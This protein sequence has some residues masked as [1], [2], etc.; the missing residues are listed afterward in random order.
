MFALNIILLLVE[1]NKTKAMDIKTLRTKYPLLLRYLQDQGVSKSTLYNYQREIKVMLSPDSDISDMDQYCHRL[2]KTCKDKGQTLYRRLACIKRIWR[3]VT[4]EETPRL[5]TIPLE[6]M[7]KEYTSLL[8]TCKQKSKALGHKEK[9]TSD[10][11]YALRSFFVYLYGRQVT[12]LK[13][14]SETIVQEYFTDGNTAKRSRSI[15]G[16]LRRVFVMFQDSIGIEVA[17]RLSSFIPSIPNTTH[18]YPD[19]SEEEASSIE[20]V[21][22]DSNIKMPDVDRAIGSLA[23]FMG[24]RSSDII[25]LR[26][27]NIDFK[28]K[29]IRLIQQKTDVPL[30]L[31]IPTV[32]SN[33][34]VKYVR[35]SRPK[36]PCTAI[37]VQARTGNTLHKR[38]LYNI[39]NDILRLAGVS[40]FNRKMRGLHLYRHHFASSLISHDTDVSIA[41]GLLGH[42][43]PESTF[44]YLGTDIT[45]LRTCALLL[46]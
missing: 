6:V 7:P 45:K 27:E 12:H 28:N 21:L 37:F 41:S 10:Y 36:S 31:P 35:D 2:E 24:L 44:A 46:P 39:S 29:T 13:D 9:T 33:A 4:E 30:T 18:I 32:C 15:S 38:D 34:I 43:C 5:K 23:F 40:L 8:D 22:T 11:I 26:K 1:T 25:N 3:Y 17:I 42:T 14:V 16:R 19:L 20:K